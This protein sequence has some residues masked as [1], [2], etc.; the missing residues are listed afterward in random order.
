MHIEKT[1]SQNSWK[2]QMCLM[3]GLLLTMVL[4]AD[5]PRKAAEHMKL[6]QYDDAMRVYADL[7]SRKPDDS[8]YLYNAGVA[9][10][11]AQK[12]QEA[13]EYF[14]ASSLS[15]DLGL[16]QQ[17]FYNRGN[18]L[19]KSGESEAEFEK[20]TQLW[21]EAL[22]QF[23]HAVKLNDTDKLATENLQF[24]KT[25][26]ENLQEQEQEQENQ[27]NEDQNEDDKQQDQ[28]QQDQDQQDQD[29]QDQDNK[30]Q[31]NKDQDNKEDS[32][33]GSNQDPSS[34]EDQE[35]LKQGDQDQENPEKPEDQEQKQS[36]KSDKNQ[37]EE[38]ASADQPEEGKG[39]ETETAATTMTPQQAM[40]LL[41]SAKDEAKALIFKPQENKRKQRFKDW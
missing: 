21:K 36:S 34:E 39:N 25:Q 13:Q 40:Q 1:L 37:E 19:Y 12:F 9:A 30:D 4:C 11:K 28:D 6:G 33:E 31:D 3:V 23:D 20:K 2:I 5:S 22:D 26:L 15:S 38:E 24:V 18:A 16:Q 32:S 17:S 27:S 29:Q 8:R 7:A 41:E 10:Y 14:D 35:D